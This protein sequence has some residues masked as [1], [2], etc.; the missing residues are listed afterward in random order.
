M[1]VVPFVEGGGAVMIMVSHSVADGGAI[2]TSI[3]DAV[4]GRK[5]DYG[6]S[7]PHS[8]TRRQAVREDLKSTAASLPEL[9]KAVRAAVRVARK[10]KADIR[11]SAKRSVGRPIEGTAS[12]I[13][14]PSVTAL[15][16][17]AEWDQRAA[18]LG[19]TSNALVAGI[20][21]RLGR[22]RG[23]VDEDGLVTLNMPVSDRT[24]GDTRANALSGCR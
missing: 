16:D 21:A 14:V 15:V 20:A 1:A 18:A 4:S 5:R 6:Y 3:V 13:P 19:G 22:Y 7:Q 17:I 2:F 24:K 8:R 12:A 23:R 9:A 11:S 10:E